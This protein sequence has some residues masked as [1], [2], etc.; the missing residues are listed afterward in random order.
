MQGRGHPSEPSFVAVVVEWTSEYAF[1]IIVCSCSLIIVA[2][3]IRWR[4]APKSREA[5]ILDRQVDNALDKFRERCFLAL[6]QTEPLDNNRVTIF[7]HVQW[8]WWIW[9][10][11]CC[12]SPWGW[13]RC[14]G[15]GWLVVAHRSGHTTQS[16][17]TVFLAPDDADQAD[18]IAGQTWRRKN[19]Y[20]VR[21]LPDLGAISYVGCIGASWLWL[22][23][24][25]VPTCPAVTAYSEAGRN[26]EQYAKATTTTP[27]LV[28]LRIKGKKKLP[29]SMCGIPLE[30]RKN[31]PIGVLVLDSCNTYECIDTDTR[32]FRGALT[33]LT[34]RLHELGV[35]E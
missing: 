4:L 29:L 21:N 28:W 2:R 13:C 34:N 1:W 15:S 6:P 9:P 16:S 31:I 30:S 25:W 17:G 7:K 3:F 11:R 5:E 35:L 14:P 8:R 22:R 33:R 26:I 10:W 12:C 32:S 19:A 18:G 24:L 27:R 23:A 20:R